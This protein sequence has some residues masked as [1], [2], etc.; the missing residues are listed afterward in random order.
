[1]I[2]RIRYEFRCKCSID[3]NTVVDVVEKLDD[4]NSPIFTW[5]SSVLLAAFLFHQKHTLQLPYIVLNN[6]TT[7]IELGSGTSLPSLLCA[8]M[9]VARCFITERADQPDLFGHI[10]DL[11]RLNSVQ[12]HCKIVPFS[13]GYGNFENY[14]DIPQIDVIL[15]ADIFYCGEEFDAILFT[16]FQLLVKNPHA[17]FVTSYQDRE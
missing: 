13:W 4:E 2:E 11:I 17:V 16:V 5:P 8:K 3:S 12:E 6:A 10:V 7:I 14:D 1:M 9:G 15:G